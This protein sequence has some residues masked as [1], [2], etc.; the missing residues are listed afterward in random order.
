MSMARARDS[1][2]DRIPPGLSL[3]TALNTQLLVWRGA[4]LKS[5]GALVDIGDL[6]TPAPCEPGHVKYPKQGGVCGVGLGSPLGGSSGRVCWEGRLGGSAGL[7]PL[8]REAGSGRGPLYSP[9][10]VTGPLISF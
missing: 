2:C 9:H 10:F 7:P 3:L 4:G 1:T 8:L 5:T 6:M